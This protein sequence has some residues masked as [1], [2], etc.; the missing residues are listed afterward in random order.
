ML[1]TLMSNLPGMI[2]QCSNDPD[3]TMRFVS[4]GCLDLTGHQPSDL[5]NNARVSYADLIHP[6]DRQAVWDTIQ[7]SVKTNTPFQL[8]YRITA[9]DGRIKWVWEQGRGVFSPSGQLESLE[10]YITDIT[11]R[12]QAEEHLRFLATAVEQITEG[13]VVSD[14]DGQL[15]FVNHAIEATHGYKPE[16]LIGKHLSI[17]HSPEQMPA[18][19]AAL[20]QIRR[21]GHFEGELD[22]LRRNGTVA[23][24]FMHTTLLRDEQDKPIG[25]IAS[26]RDITG[27]KKVL[28]ALHKERNFN[29]TVVQ[30]SPTFFVAISAEGKTLTMND[31]MLEALGYRLDEVVGKDYLSTFVPQSDREALAGIFRQIITTDQPAINDNR[32]LTRDGRELLVEWHGRQI[33][34]EDGRLDYFFGIG[35]DIT[36][37]RKDEEERARLEAQLYQIQKLEAIGQLAGGVAHDFNN[38]LAVIMGNA[39]IVKRDSN[40]TPKVRDALADIVSAA[41]RG[42]TLTQQLLTYARGGLQPPCATDLNRL[43]RSV[44]PMLERAAPTKVRFSLRLQD[45]LP[46]ILADPP[47]IEQIILNLCLNAIQATT[48]PGTIT[49][50]TNDEHLDTKAAADLQLSPGRYVRFEVHDEGCGIAPEIQDRIFEPFFSTKEMG[51]GMGLAVTHGII[52]SHRGQIRIQSRLGQGTTITVWMPT[53]NQSESAVQ[54]APPRPSVHRP[55]RG[56]ETI[57]LIDDEPALAATVEKMLSSLGYCAI[58]H[59]DADQALAFLSNNAEDVHLVLCDLSMPK[60]SGPQ[61]ASLIARKYPHIAVLLTSGY[62]ADTVAEQIRNTRTAGFVQKPLSLHSLAQAIRKALDH[63]PSS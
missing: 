7:N 51:R 54:T 60:H 19:E 31:A 43:I 18:V 8:T 13:I 17:F 44:T 16:E 23:T 6:D 58:S 45:H 15:L 47:R 49:I 35:I 56:D 38:L 20:E 63:P 46:S 59:T 55:P 41:E 52:Q 39:S 27:Q 50:S 22:H 2:Y 53:T 32:V 29:R 21:E 1:L 3:W 40:L 12:K 61:I 37:R 62:D 48:S 26:F 28:E 33:F 25:M 5:I 57:L 36:Q 42:S 24:M 11:A 30:A 9:A 4:Q 34:K 10:G 14:L